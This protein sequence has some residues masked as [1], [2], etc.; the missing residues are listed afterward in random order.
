MEL[1]TCVTTPS[2]LDSEHLNHTLTRRDLFKIKYLIK[3]QE[4]SV[5]I[6]F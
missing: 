6:T 3:S 5:R 1:I 4:H 2:E